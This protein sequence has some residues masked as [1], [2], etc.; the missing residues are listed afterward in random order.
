MALLLTPGVDA[1]AAGL[2]T[3]K[4]EIKSMCNI[5]DRL[6]TL[7]PFSSPAVTIHLKLGIRLLTVVKKA[8][9]EFWGIPVY[10]I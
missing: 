5:P 1:A 3:R 10:G 9:I 4:C 2:P 7:H 8:P 6:T